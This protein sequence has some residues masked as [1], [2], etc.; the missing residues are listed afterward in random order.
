MFRTWMSAFNVKT[1]RSRPFGWGEIVVIVENRGSC[2]WDG[3]EVKPWGKAW[4]SPNPD[5]DGE[6]D[7]TRGQRIT[8]ITRLPDSN[9]HH[10]YL[11][12]TAQKKRRTSP[13]SRFRFLAT[14]SSR[15]VL[16]II[17]HPGHF[18]LAPRPL[19]CT[20]YPSSFILGLTGCY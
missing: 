3:V 20:T 2:A 18:I 7:D 6:I 19:P 11:V 1:A 15:I 5:G 16:P 12:E 9:S 8:R 4:K 14:F 13:L 10:A 17:P